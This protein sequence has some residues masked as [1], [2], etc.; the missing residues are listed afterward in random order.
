MASVKAE[1]V[2]PTIIVKKI[3][4]KFQGIEGVGE[5]EGRFDR[6]STSVFIWNFCTGSAQLTSKTSIKIIIET[7]PWNGTEVR[8][9]AFK[10]GKP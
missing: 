6:G 7:A 8:V 9:A 2:F 5:S 3:I 1:S 4:P 10:L